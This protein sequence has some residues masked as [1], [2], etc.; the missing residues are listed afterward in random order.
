MSAEHFPAEHD[1]YPNRPMVLMVGAFIVTL[2]LIAMAVIGI[3]YMILWL[4]QVR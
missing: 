4:A 2:G 1:N 3:I